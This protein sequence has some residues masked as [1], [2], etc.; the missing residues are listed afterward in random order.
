MSKPML[1]AVTD[2]ASYDASDHEEGLGF[3]K[4]KRVDPALAEP[5]NRPDYMSLSKTLEPLITEFGGDPS[6]DENG[7]THID[8]SKL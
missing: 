1:C 8:W 6:I 4:V 2:D 3:Y 5:E 7:T